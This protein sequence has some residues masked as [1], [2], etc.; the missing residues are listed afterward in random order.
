[1]EYDD[2][3]ILNLETESG[4]FGRV[5]QDVVWRPHRKKSVDS[6][7]SRR[8]GVDFRVFIRRR[9]LDPGTTR[10]SG[11]TFLVLKNKAG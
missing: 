4:L 1:M 10:G 11:L 7:E 5:V 8:S 2:V 3:A 9:C 6:M